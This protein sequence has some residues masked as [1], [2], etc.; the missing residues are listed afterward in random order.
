MPSRERSCLMCDGAKV[1]K[2]VTSG[3]NKI[4]REGRIG[5]TSLFVCL[6]VCLFGN[7][8]PLNCRNKG[9]YRESPVPVYATARRADRLSTS[10]RGSHARTDRGQI[11]PRA[12][13]VIVITR[14]LEYSAFHTPLTL[15]NTSGTTTRVGR[16]GCCTQKSTP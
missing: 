7:A 3:R 1:R 15:F 14:R 12:P 2:R 10:V 6:F 4:D 8:V 11:L 9:R 13:V 16:M 5:A